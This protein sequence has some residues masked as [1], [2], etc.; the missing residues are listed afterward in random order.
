[1]AR[2]RDHGNEC[3]QKMSGSSDIKINVFPNWLSYHHKLDTRRNCS[4]LGSLGT[5]TDMSL[6]A[7]PPGMP[8][9]IEIYFIIFT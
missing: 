6:R 9:R 4:S 7:D 1:M 3:L 8:K 5:S 2:S